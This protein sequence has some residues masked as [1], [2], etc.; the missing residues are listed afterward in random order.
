MRPGRT[1]TLAR[2]QWKEAEARGAETA[3]EASALP[4][5][6]ADLVGV[7]LRQAIEEA[8]GA[9]AVAGAAAGHH[10]TATD[11]LRGADSSG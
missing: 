4:A 5:G 11:C 6:L 2:S 9:A 8:E 7:A 1:T 3:F 10:E